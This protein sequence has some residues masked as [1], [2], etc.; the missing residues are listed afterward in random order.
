MAIMN[1][2]KSERS[3][4]RFVENNKNDLI[5]YLQIKRKRLPTR[6]II[7]GILQK[8]DFNKLEKIFYEW[9]LYYVSIEEKDWISVDG[10]SIRGTVRNSQNKKHNFKSLVS[11]FASKQKQIISA[12]K[13]EIKKENEIPVVKKLIK[14]LDLE[15]VIFTLDA[16]HCQKE[17]VKEIIKSKND[18]VI[19]VKGN[20]K[21]L[22]KQIKKT[23]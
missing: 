19:G 1:G 15:G 11:I 6:N 9:A 16:I 20:Q 17:T 21:K 2:S 10:K 4:S 7:R 23:L 5:K 18:F 14:A 8:V 13:L 3:I 12:S 22:L